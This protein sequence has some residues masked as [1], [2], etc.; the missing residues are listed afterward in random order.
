MKLKVLQTDIKKAVRVIEGITKINR[1][2]WGK[3]NLWGDVRWGKYKDVRFQC[4]CPITQAVRRQSKSKKKV[5]TTYTVVTVGNKS[6]QLPLIA[7]EFISK[8]DHGKQVSPIQ[9]ELVSN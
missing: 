6:F 9:I 1:K 8:F 3:V 4:L 7:Q 2:D 5:R